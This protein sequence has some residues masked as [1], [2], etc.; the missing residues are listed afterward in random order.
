MADTIQKVDYFYTMVPDKPGE[1]AR[2]L[3]VLREAGVNLLVFSGFPEGRRGQLDF[4]PADAGAFRQAAKKA[5]WKL[6]GPRRA[7]LLQGEDRVGAVAETLGRLAA[8]KIN[9]TAID[10]V[11]AGAGRYGAILWVPQRDVGRAAKVL[12]V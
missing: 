8:A 3:A 1:A 10:A 2:M 7:F 6:T 5:G 11:C 9:V 12:G 4:V